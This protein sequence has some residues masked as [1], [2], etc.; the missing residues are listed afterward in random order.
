MLDFHGEGSHTTPQHHWDREHHGPPNPLGRLPKMDFPKFTGANPKLWLSRCEDHFEMYSV[1]PSM[2]VRVARGHMAETAELWLQSVEDTVRTASWRTFC[3]MVLE[4]FG[5]D[6]HELLI[7]QLFNIHMSGTVSEYITE[8]TK[9]VEQLIAYG[10]HTDPIYF[11]MRFVDGLRDDIRQ[12]VHMHRPSTLDS[13]CSLA[14]LQEEMAES[15]KHWNVR[16]TD[17]YGGIKHVPRGPPHLPPPPRPDKPVLPG[18]PPVIEGRRGRGVDDKLTALRDYRR[19]RGLC[20]R[21]GE[22]WSRDHRCSEQIALH[23]L[24][25]TWDLCNPDD[26]EYEE[27]A[28]DGDQLA[29]CCVTISVAATQGIQASRTIQ[30]QGELQGKSVVILLDSGSSHSFVSE[31]LAVS[32]SGT[33]SR[34]AAVWVQV[35]DGAKIRC[36]TQ[37]TDAVWSVQGLQFTSTLKIFPLTTF[38]MI[39]GMDWLEQY[40]PMKIHWL[41]K[42]IQFPYASD[43]AVIRGDGASLPVGSVIHLSVTQ[44]SEPDSGAAAPPALAELLVE[45]ADIFRSPTALPPRRHCDHAIPLLPGTAPVSIRPYRYPPAIKDEI[46]RQ[47]QMMLDSGVIQH[48]DSPFSSPVLL[49]KKKDGSF[50]FCVDFRHLNAITAKSKYP[51]PIIEELL[52]ELHGASWFSSLD[53]TAGYHQ[54]LL[55]PGEEPKT[56]FQTHTGH[57][58]FRVMAFG[59]S[60]APGT[61]LKAMNTT[62]APLLRRCVLVF[63]DDILIYSRSFEDHLDHLQATFALLRQDQWLVKRSKCAFGQRQLRYLGHII[64]ES[65]VATDPAKISAVLQWPSPTS[66]K[67]LRSFLGLAGYYR[68][69]VRNF[70]IIAKP[71]T[72][73]LRKGTLFIWTL[74][75]QQ[76]FEVLKTALTSAPVLA[77]PNFQIPFVIET[78]ASGVGIGAVLMQSGHPLAFLSKALGPRSQ[79]LSAYEKEYMAIIMAVDHWRSYLQAAEFHIITDQRSLV[80]LSTQRL[81]TPWQQKLFTKLLGLQYTIRYRQGPENR[82]AD[83]LS[84][85]PEPGVMCDSISVA[86]P[87]WTQAIAASYQDDPYAQ[88]LITK[89]AIDPAAVPHFSF[90]DGLL[91][92][93]GRLWVGPDPALHQQ[94]LAALH[95]SPVGG[96]SGIPVTLRR[97]KQ[98]FAWRG[99]TTAVRDFVSSCTICQQA[100]PDRSRLPGLLQPLPVPDR[101]WQV[102]S[103]DFIEGLPVSGRFNAILVIVD[104][105]SKYAH[106]VGLRHP[107]TAATV[108]STFMQHIYRLHG[109]PSAIVSDRDKIF[110][111]KLWSEL[112]RLAQVELRMSTAYHPQSDGQTERVNQCL[113]TFLRCYVHACPS[114]WS[115][116]IHL[117][118]YWYNCSHHS[119]VGRSPFEALYG[120]APSHFGIS[121]A[122]VS[123][124]NDLAT[125]L[126]ERQLMTA[127]IRQHLLRAKARMV[128]TANLRRSERQFAIGD[129]VYLKLQPYVQSSVAA[130]ANHKLSFKFFGPYQVLAKVG[131]V[132]YKLALPASSTIHPVFHVSQ[133]KKSVGHQHSVT[134][135][136]P[137]SDLQWSIPVA[138]LQ[139]RTVPA[140]ASTKVQGLIRWSNMPDSLATWEDLIPLQQAFPRAPVWGQP[141]PPGGEDVTT[142]EPVD[143]RDQGKATDGPSDARPRRVKKPNPKTSGPS[144]VQAILEA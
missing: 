59:L 41:E 30:F 130:R 96:H 119:A 101:A 90:R 95:S 124:S 114:K 44:D 138:I 63:F 85:F 93:K 80:Q 94:L 8:Y 43:W 99:L 11:A 60:G 111:S 103:M 75:H 86:T 68:R 122:D 108:A 89:L 134:E 77:L 18:H 118:E 57:Y 84:R 78:D 33:L 123:V 46:E 45:F 115:S 54:I 35:A 16:R 53:L 29:Q 14:L 107:F 121:A 31:S 128:K 98:L 27:I 49:V 24:Q 67:E 25:E 40:S 140:G 113:E 21:C 91:R 12:A 102:I 127:L 69:F 117:A 34:S 2:W 73:L 72:D 37:L 36:D 82:V 83:A 58:E 133:L 4:R 116:W 136:P 88:D 126:D 100:K 22:K 135:S 7:R 92:Y 1:E 137:D 9:I 47:V 13:A 144:W 3:L 97:A 129:W 104:L 110:T 125:W 56:A 39:L 71:L 74:D 38:D 26:L 112:F 61:F 132:A 143:A 65:G 52:D 79:G 50:R 55:K 81:H 48:S 131:S 32:L 142:V 109:M 87:A 76:A 6:H 64:S 51:V 19:A 106:F 66:V 62:L 28:A 23:V 139:R 15:G 141:G 120:Y 20:Y 5:K 42:W 10:K 105:F 17:Q 70:G